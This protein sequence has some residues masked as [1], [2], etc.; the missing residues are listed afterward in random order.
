[1]DD[2]VTQA[3]DADGRWHVQSLRE[4]HLRLD[5]A[6]RA[7][8]RPVSWP[9]E[10]ERVRRWARGILSDPELVVLDVQTTA[11]HNP[12]AVQIAMT[13]RFGDV[14]FNEHL[15]PFAAIAPT[16]TALHGITPGQAAA[17]PAFSA[18]VPRLSRL[19]NGRRCL[20]YNA[21]FDRGV[22]ERELR[23]HF[24]NTTRAQTWLGNCTWVDAMRP[25]AAWKGLWSAHRC[26]YRYQA[27]GSSYEAVK[28]CRLLLTTVRQIKQ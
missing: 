17:A 21:S 2:A 3:R 18:F 20:A 8:H 11:P 9:I 6:I 19:L 1:M 12:W 25:Y 7:L 14:L 15:N 22:L 5:D 13:D 28:N 10:Q 23:R 27:L 24:R 16:A 4:Q 26:S